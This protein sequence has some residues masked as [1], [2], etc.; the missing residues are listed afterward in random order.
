MVKTR[1]TNYTYE[2]SWSMP[3]SQTLASII[4]GKLND[5][6][7]YFQ[8]LYETK[9]TITKKWKPF[10]NY[11]NM[12]SHYNARQ[13]MCIYISIWCLIYFITILHQ[14]CK[15]QWKF[16][17]SG[18]DRFESILTDWFPPK[19]INTIEFKSFLSFPFHYLYCSFYWYS[20]QLQSSSKIV[21]LSCLCVCLWFERVNLVVNICYCH[22][23]SC[24]LSHTFK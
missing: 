18:K 9:Q 5:V 22:M 10:H 12:Q 23:F 3:F 7:R 1:G 16:K 8:V 13:G 19:G 24:F 2:W 17:D 11:I 15:K 6:Y 21:P 4:N 14:T 20:L